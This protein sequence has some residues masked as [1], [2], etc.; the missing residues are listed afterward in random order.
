MNSQGNP[1]TR[2]AFTLIEV[3]LVLAIGMVVF[4]F[5]VRS[6]N[7]GPRKAPQMVCLSNQKQLGIGFLLYSS[8]HG[9]FPWGA[10][11]NSGGTQELLP[12]GTAADQFVKLRPYLHQPRVFVCPTDE[13][14]QAAATNFLGFSNS[15]LSYFVSFDAARA[16]TSTSGPVAFIL[17]GDRHLAYNDQPV[18]PGLFSVTNPTVMGWTKQ[19]HHMKNTVKTIGVLT[20]ADGHA[21][22]VVTPRLADKFRAQMIAT[23]QL[24]IP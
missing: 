14:R 6:V 16:L 3:L 22:A 20:F 7:Q 4:L 19:L 10:L 13:Q 9:R 21:E 17:T 23:N 2:R 12:N 5:F 8:D 24:V 11:T 18:K 15:N 1:I